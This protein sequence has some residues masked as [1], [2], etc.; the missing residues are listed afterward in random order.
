M[1]DLMIDLETL[2][3]KPGCAILSIGAC[4]FDRKTGDIG[5]TFYRE[6]SIPASEDIGLL[7]DA[8]TVEWWHKQSTAARELLQRC[9]NYKMHSPETAANLFTNWLKSNTSADTNGIW[10]NDPTFDHKI[11]EHMLHQTGNKTPWPFFLERSCRTIVDI[12]RELGIDPKKEMPF[13][14]TPH[15]ALDDAI[16]QAKYVSAI[17]QHINSLKTAA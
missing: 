5:K 8:S 15:N 2:G 16:H 3:K 12:G 7:I 1:T 17:Y 9:D 14:G 11:L 6:I 13:E 10:A 4:V